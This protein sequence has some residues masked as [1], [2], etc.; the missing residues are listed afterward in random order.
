MVL[1]VLGQR[2]YFRVVPEAEGVRR[3]DSL[4]RPATHA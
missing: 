3:R 2:G 4:N 1:F